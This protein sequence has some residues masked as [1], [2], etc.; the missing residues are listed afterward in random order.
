MAKGSFDTRT[1]KLKLSIGFPQAL[2]NRINRE[3]TE[4]GVSFGRHVID[5]V[6]AAYRIDAELKRRTPPMEHTR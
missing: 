2:F 6:E 3:A 1:G 5:L 4:K